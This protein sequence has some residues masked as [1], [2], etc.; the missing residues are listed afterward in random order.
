M[1]RGYMYV[2]LSVGFFMFYLSFLFRVNI[3]FWLC[4]YDKDID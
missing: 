4:G 1:R 3:R 2:R